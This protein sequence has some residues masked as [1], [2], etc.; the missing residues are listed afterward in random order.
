MDIRP[1][2]IEAHYDAAL[3]EIAK[4]SS[5][6]PEPGSPNGDRFRASCP[7]ERQLRGQALADRVI[8]CLT[9][10][11]CFDPLLPFSVLSWLRQIGHTS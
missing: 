8:R 5:I 3:H 2:K 9:L 10:I 7:G 1:L 6:S 11:L 4:Y